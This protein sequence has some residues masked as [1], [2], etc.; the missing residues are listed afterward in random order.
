MEIK[1]WI[2]RKPDGSMKS[3]KTDSHWYIVS[4]FYAGYINK[5]PVL[6]VANIENYKPLSYC[7]CHTVVMQYCFLCDTFFVDVEWFFP[8]RWR[9]RGV[10]EAF[11]SVW[12]MDQVKFSCGIT[13]ANERSGILDSPGLLHCCRHN[14]NKMSLNWNICP[15][16]LL[17][18]SWQLPYVRYMW[19]HLPWFHCLCHWKPRH[20]PPL[21]GIWHYMVCSAPGLTEICCSTQTEWK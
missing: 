5:Y 15:I 4:C 12:W 11:V 21:C 6:Y 7:H 3:K 13:A 18:M 8:G 19:Q 9:Q 14:L 2:R 16:R 20:M 17:Y 10:P 1:S